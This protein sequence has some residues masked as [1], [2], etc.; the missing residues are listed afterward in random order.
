M[1]E[2]ADNFA[3]KHKI[4]IR[5][6]GALP[7]NL[8]A[9]KLEDAEGALVL[10]DSTQT[11]ERQNFGLAHE[12]AHVLLGHRD[13]LQP[14]EESEAN[15]L[16]SELMLPASD[17]VADSG[18]SLRELKE[19]YPHASFEV[20]GRR[21]LAYQQGVL[22]IIDNQDL[23]RRLFS[24]SFQAPPRPVES[25]WKC[26]RACYDTK[27]DIQMLEKELSLTA[28]YVDEGRGVLRVLLWTEEV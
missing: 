15:E 20:L 24:D 13:E 21:K 4:R 16:A 6:E 11:E 26:I 18:L 3:R 2:W 9:F 14:E 23:T 7:N 8:P 25:E 28:T 27:S 19:Y 12:V 17:F 5:Y 22:T 1:S 10:I